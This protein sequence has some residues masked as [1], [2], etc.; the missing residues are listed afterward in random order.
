[1]NTE[2]CIGIQL[3]KNYKEFLEGVTTDKIRISSSDRKR[4]ILSA[5]WQALGMLGSDQWKH[6]MESFLNK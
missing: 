4:T 2:Y 5:L 3:K 6:E 1:M